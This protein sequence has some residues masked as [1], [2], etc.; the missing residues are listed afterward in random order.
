MATKT[1][2]TV[3]SKGNA[4]YLRVEET[5]E[6]GYF[7]LRARLCTQ[8][9]DSANSCWRPLGVD[10]GYSDGLLWSGLR[11]SCQ[12]DEKS[13]LRADGRGESGP[14]Y[15]FDTE[16]H[17]EYGQ[18]VDLRK[19]RRMHKTLELVA[20]KLAALTEARGYVRSYGEY[21]GRVGEALGCA[22]MCF[23]RHTNGIVNPSWRS[24]RWEDLRWDW[25]SIGDGVN[26]ANHRIYLWQQQAVE[27]GQQ[28]QGE[29]AAS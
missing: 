29:E 2:T 11:C 18:H 10:D 13:Q 28:L 5:H 9:Y 24:Q 1:K 20:K 19:V 14:V 15:G 21:L 27:R 12:G 3:D 23:Q 4:L 8:E 17:D 7:H 6:G 22:G 25:M 16:Y 26:R